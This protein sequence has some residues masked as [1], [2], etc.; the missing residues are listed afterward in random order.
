MIRVR[1]SPAPTGSLHIGSA[2]TALFNWLYAR[3]HDGDVRAPHRGH[4]RRPQHA[5]SGSSGSRTRCGG[6]ASTGTKGR[7][8]R[9]R[10][11]TVYLAAADRLLAAG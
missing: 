7:S 5:R 11:S 4:R 10:A 3:H 8:S 9:A 1:F 2:R 6:S